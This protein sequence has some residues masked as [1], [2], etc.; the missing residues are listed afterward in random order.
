MTSTLIPTETIGNPV[1]EPVADNIRPP[2][3]IADAIP[4]AVHLPADARGVALGILATVALIFALDWARPFL[5]TLLPGIL[6]AYT[7]NPL[8]SSN[9]ER[10]YASA[11]GAAIPF[12]NARRPPVSLCVLSHGA[13][14]HALAS[15]FEPGQGV[16]KMDDKGGRMDGGMQR[17]VRN[18]YSVTCRACSPGASQL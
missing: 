7:L 18:G 16:L 17:H 8:V 3:R 15:C 1:S 2:A 11:R 10:L 5:I 14:R 9:G 12:V 13:R 4:L 6:F